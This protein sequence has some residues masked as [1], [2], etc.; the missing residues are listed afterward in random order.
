MDLNRITFGF[1]VWQ[2]Q[3]TDG[4]YSFHL[5]SDWFQD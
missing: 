1:T 3:Q 4:P 2:A 5:L